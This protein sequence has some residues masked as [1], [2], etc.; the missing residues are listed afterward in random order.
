MT[1]KKNQKYEFFP[2]IFRSP[3]ND[4]SFNDEK[5]LHWESY[6]LHQKY[7]ELGESTNF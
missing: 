5:I 7:L 1:L 3:N 6:D 4:E 2:L